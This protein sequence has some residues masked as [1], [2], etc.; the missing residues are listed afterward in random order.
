MNLPKKPV[1]WYLVADSKTA[2]IYV[3]NITEKIVPVN[4]SRTAKTLN[5]Y[6]SRLRIVPGM[7][8]KAELEEIY[9]KN[10]KAGKI[11]QSSSPAHHMSQPHITIEEEI[12]HH[13]A[14]YIAKQL[15]EKKLERAFDHL[16]IIAPPRILGLL[17]KDLDKSV[18]DSII[19]KMPKNL[20]HLRE[21][22]LA[23]YLGNIFQKIRSIKN[24]KRRT[25]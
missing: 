14:A 10:N 19:A 15:N 1:T 3:R 8:F 17:R 16:V 5:V 11:F 6:E 9:E 2:R 22:M 7:E 18:I 21:D 13:F 24:F 25:I 20:T 4:R 23:V 12:R